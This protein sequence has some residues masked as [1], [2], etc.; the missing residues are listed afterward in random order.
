[1]S[2]GKYEAGTHTSLLRSSRAF[3]QT[4][5][6]ITYRFEIWPSKT[7]PCAFEHRHGAPSRATY[8]F[9]RH[10]NVASPARIS[11]QRIAQ[12][13]TFLD[14]C[15]LPPPQNRCMQNR[16]NMG[17]QSFYLH[18]VASKL[19]PEGGRRCQKIFEVYCIKMHEACPERTL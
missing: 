13:I 3:Q 5:T 4:G 7:P 11:S 9:A 6:V 2:S 19:H 1:M 18:P 15:P 16:H 12:H 14:R 8:I 10:R 17:R